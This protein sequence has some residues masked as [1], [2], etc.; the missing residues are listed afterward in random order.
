MQ[1]ARPSLSGGPTTKPPPSSASYTTSSRA[2]A[3]PSLLASALL[4]RSSTSS[5]RRQRVSPCRPRRSMRRRGL[6]AEGAATGEIPA[7]PSDDARRRRGCRSAVDRMVPGAP[8]PSGAGPDR[9]RP[10]L[11]WQDAR[12]RVARAACV[13]AMWR[14]SDR[15]RGYGRAAAGYF[16]WAP[17][18]S[19]ITRLTENRG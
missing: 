6:F 5:S 18:Q 15:F 19:P 3:T 1:E 12:P 10:T 2:T 17:W 13:L 14:P 11:R 7:R 8:T 9:A 4:E 16:D